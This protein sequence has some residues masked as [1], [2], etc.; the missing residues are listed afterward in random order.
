[1]NKPSESPGAKAAFLGALRRHM[2]ALPGLVIVLLV[3]IAHTFQPGVVSELRNLLFDFYQRLEPRPFATVPV[4]IVDIDDESLTRLGQWPWPRTDL[5]RLATTLGQAGAAAVAFDIIFS[6]PDRTSPARIAEVLRKDPNASGDYSMI[7]RLPDHDLTFGRSLSAVPAVTGFI[8]VHSPNSVRPETKAG[9]AISG[10]APFDSLPAYRGAIATLPAI[11]RGAAGNGFFSIAPAADG[12]VRAAPLLAHLGNRLYP[13]LALEALRVAQG[14]STV[15]VKTTSGSGEIAGGEPGIVDIKVGNFVVPTTKSGELWMYYRLPRADD[16]VSAWK[17]L[18]GALNAAQLKNLFDGEIVF[19]GTSAEGLRDIVAT[20][21]ASELGAAIH[22][23]AIEQMI[24]GRFLVRPDWSFGA[25]RLLLV[26]FGFGLSFSL[27]ALGALRGGLLSAVVLSA[28]AATSWLSFL[29]GGLLLDP[30]Y[31][32][33]EIVAVYIACVGFAYY[34]EEV[35]RAYIQRAFDRYLSPELVERIASDP[36]QLKLGGEE[37]HMTVLF[38]DIRGFSHISEKLSPQATI[39][40]LVDFLTPMSEVLLGEKA[41][42][43]KF[44]GDAIMAFWN[45]PLDDPDHARHA[46]SAALK[47]CAEIER[48]NVVNPADPA[49]T[50]PGEVHIGVGLDSGPCCVGNIGSAQRL[51]YSLIGDT[52]N[53]A[54]R[55]EGLTKIYGIPIA[56]GEGAAKELDGFAFFEI[57]KV[58]VVG[59]DMP[60]RIYA[61]IGSPDVARKLDFQDCARLQGEF[62]RCYRGR[63]WDASAALL[64]SLRPVASSFGLSRLIEL[65]TKRIAAFREA[66]PP[67]NWDGVFEAAHK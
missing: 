64:E 33:M 44:I 41:T 40:F 36:S 30:T 66:P 35:A 34:R 32:A 46:A 62:L 1:M 59:R 67:E 50:W 58:R 15:I 55:I 45:A 3:V 49:K 5:A 51:S 26:I 28:S 20:P 16:V 37:R 47:L 53:L 57:D 24:A 65:F 61:L 43:D 4:R 9:F 54:S 19:V 23:Q 17:I 29:K 7:A 25:E 63:D 12:V 48:L 10:T 27:P 38:L 39:R 31:P 14:A 13:S 11:E 52:V 18:S 56:M 21:Q 6:E 22:A 42:I 2:G 8:L 60:E